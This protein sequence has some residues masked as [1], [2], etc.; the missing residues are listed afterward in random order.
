MRER[1]SVC[2]GGGGG[3]GGGGGGGIAERK[4]E[5]IGKSERAKRKGMEAE[6]EW[7]R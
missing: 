5:T 4:G 2:C 3:A 1:E 7:T 6:K